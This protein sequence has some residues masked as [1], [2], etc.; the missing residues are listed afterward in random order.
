MTRE[1]L[2]QTIIRW[3]SYK[4]MLGIGC[5]DTHQPAEQ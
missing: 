4:P 5:D 2:N 3:L 1:K